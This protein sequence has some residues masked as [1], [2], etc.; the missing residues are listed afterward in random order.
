MA[1]SEIDRLTKRILTIQQELG[2]LH[3][4]NPP[5]LTPFNIVKW[6]AA[7]SITFGGLMLAAPTGGASLLLSLG[8]LV[9]YL[10]DIAQLIQSGARSSEDKLRAALLEQELRDHLVR[11]SRLG[12]R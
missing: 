8:G 5:K 2:E 10:I 1:D 7:G 12:R 9:I 3:R 4:R 6:V 11:I